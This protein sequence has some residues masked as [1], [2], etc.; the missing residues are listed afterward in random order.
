LKVIKR[1]I[2]LKSERILN[3]KTKLTINH[4]GI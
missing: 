2:K 1:K 3:N 4:S